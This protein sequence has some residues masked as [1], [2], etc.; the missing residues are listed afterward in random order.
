MSGGQ[1]EH[2]YYL[3]VFPTGNDEV[4]QRQDNHNHTNPSCPNLNVLRG[5]DGR[6]GQAGLPGTPGKDGCDGIPGRDGRD[7]SPGKDGHDG[8]PGKD[9]LDG[10]PGKDGRDGA[11]GKNACSSS[12]SGGAKGDAGPMGPPG[13]Q[14]PPGLQGPTGPA[15]TQGMKGEPCPPGTQVPIGG[16]RGGGGGGSV[17]VRWGRTVCPNITGTEII[18]DGFAAGSFYTN[19]GGGA[20]YQCLPK[21][22]VYSNYYPGAQG[23]S[24]IFGTEYQQDHGAPLPNVEQHN[25][26]CAVCVTSRPTLFMF[27]AKNVCPSNWTMEYD[28]Y[29]MST[30]RAAGHYRTT[31]ECVDDEPESVPGYNSNR[32]GAL[33]YHVEAVCNGLPCPPYDPQKELTCVVCT[34]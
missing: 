16:S 18:Y 33:M 31:Y 5:R 17:Y 1:Q 14:G 9:G 13:P 30:H 23:M 8:S 3:Y 19:T 27:P 29:L 32:D 20:N 2:V 7:G 12:L 26:P 24:P 10:T 4:A 28:G 22:P 15:G 11:P 21:D 6:D 34:N 25:I